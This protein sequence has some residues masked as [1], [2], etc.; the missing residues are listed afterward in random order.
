VRR[1]Q[2]GQQQQEEQDSSHILSRSGSWSDLSE[3]SL[4]KTERIRRFYAD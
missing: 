3:I 4:P 2:A 1:R